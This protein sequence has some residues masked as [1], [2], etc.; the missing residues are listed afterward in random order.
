MRVRTIIEGPSCSAPHPLPLQDG[1]R[2][3]I[4]RPLYRFERARVTAWTCYEHRITSY[5]LCE[6]GGVSFIRRT[7]VSKGRRIVSETDAWSCG[8]ARVIWAAL[9]AGRAR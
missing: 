7:V 3:L 1:H 9:L 2:T 4:W 6:A 5:E 8:E